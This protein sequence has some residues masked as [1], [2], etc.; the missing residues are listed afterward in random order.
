MWAQNPLFVPMGL[1]IA[2]LGA[3]ISENARSEGHL[4]L[5]QTHDSR[6]GLMGSETDHRPGGCAHAF[7]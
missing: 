1:E 3:H 4:D 2:G 7:T 6:F 5:A